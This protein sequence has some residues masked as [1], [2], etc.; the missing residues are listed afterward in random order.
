MSQK[1]VALVIGA[2][3]SLGSAIARVF[4]SDNYTVVVARRN[5]DELGP[6]KEEIEGKG[7]EC[8][9]FSLDARKEEDVINFIEKIENEIGEI[10][11]AVY[12]IGANIRFNILETT[13]RKY[14]KVWEMAAFGAFLMG[15]EVARK[16][17][18]RKKGTI[19]FTGATASVRGKEGFAAFSGAKQAKRAL[20]QS[21]AKELAP[22]GIHVA[23]IIVDGAI[24]TPWVNKLFPEYVKEKKKVDG[25]MKP[26]DIAQNYLVLHNQPKNAWTFEL[27]LRPWVETW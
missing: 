5:G 8:L 25:L 22:K 27:D 16:M 23:H 3:S 1:K 26:D 11:V 13:S 9:S 7:G 6:L 15:R 21:M 14:Y 10:N 2:G 19:I 17:L 20:A 4:A 12:N 18:P 24:D